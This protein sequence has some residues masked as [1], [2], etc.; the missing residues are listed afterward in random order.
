MVTSPSRS[1][2]T[3]SADKSPSTSK[4]RLSA[5]DQA[6]DDEEVD[7]LAED[8]DDEE[9]EEAAYEV[10]A[11]VGHRFSKKVGEQVFLVKWKGYPE[12]ENTWEPEANFASRELIDA[13]WATVPGKNQPGKKKAWEAAQNKKTSSNGKEKAAS[14]SQKRNGSAST[15][16]KATASTSRRRVE[17]EDEDDAMDEDEDEV[18]AVASDAEQQQQQQENVDEEDE[19]QETIDSALI[20]ATLSDEQWKEKE[21]EWKK[22]WDPLEDWEDVVEKVSSVME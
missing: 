2:K 5:A 16:S 1:R 8:D 19:D 9:D 18:A 22:K 15:R 14:S 3:Y 21:T 10:E 11:V 6:D 7:E 4:R 17:D 20:D 12:E 13:Y